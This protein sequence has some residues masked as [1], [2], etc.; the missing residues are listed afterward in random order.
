MYV[1]NLDMNI[2]IKKCLPSV[3]SFT[4]S[5]QLIFRSLK[6]DYFSR[7]SSTLSIEELTAKS[8]QANEL[9]EKL[10]NQI[11]QIKLASTPASMAERAKNLQKENEVLKK[12]VEE[13]KVQLDEVEHKSK[14]DLI[15]R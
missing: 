5:S 11:E 14:F 1:Q 4:C 8:A 7:M 12:K 15:V 2:L 10:K 9:I 13:L 6:P 3:S